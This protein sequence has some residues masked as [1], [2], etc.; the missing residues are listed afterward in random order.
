MILCWR[1]SDNDVEPVACEAEVFG[2]PHSTTTGETMFQ[3]THFRTREEA[4]ESID[5]SISAH[6]SLA[7]NDVMDARSRMRK[8]ESHMLEAGMRAAERNK[9]RDG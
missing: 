1:G 2:H 9:K 6:L 4:W 7:Y 8:A 5:R 3:N